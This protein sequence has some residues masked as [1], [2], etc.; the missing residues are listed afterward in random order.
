MLFTLKQIDD[1]FNL[2]RTYKIDGCRT[3][4]QTSEAYYFDFLSGVLYSVSNE[5][6]LKWELISSGRVKRNRIS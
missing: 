3:Y 1:F 4:L 2:R 6:S 5:I